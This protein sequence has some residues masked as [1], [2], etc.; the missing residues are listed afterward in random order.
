MYRIICIFSLLK[1]LVRDITLYIDLCMLVK[2]LRTPS[3]TFSRFVVY[4]N[5]IQNLLKFFEKLPLFQ[6][7]TYLKVLMNVGKL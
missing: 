4:D 5:L 1:L 6:M 7:Y 3:P 2:G